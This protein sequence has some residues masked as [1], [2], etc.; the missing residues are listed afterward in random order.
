[1]YRISIFV[2]IVF[3]LLIYYIRKYFKKDYITMEYTE[4]GMYNN[5][6]YTSNC[7]LYAI[8]NSHN[9]DKS[10]VNIKIG[11]NID[12]NKFNQKDDNFLLEEL[13][14]LE[15]IVNNSLNSDSIN[16]YVN[17]MNKSAIDFDTSLSE[18]E[19]HIDN[20]DIYVKRVKNIIP[21]SKQDKINRLNPEL[22]DSAYSD[23]MQKP[24]RGTDST[25]NET[26]EI[27]N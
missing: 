10:K 26:I 6:D 2:V 8:D 11:C 20:K 7:Q 5:Y 22:P 14:Y 4:N 15:N 3:I 23:E 9:N 1:M 21:G 25:L 24:G 13:N 18:K 12:A 17:D 27:I 19:I 16:K